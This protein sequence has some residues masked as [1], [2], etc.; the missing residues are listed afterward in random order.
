M[1]IDISV[2]AKLTVRLQLNIQVEMSSRQS[3]CKSC[4]KGCAWVEEIHLGVISKQM[5][6]GKIPQGNNVARG[7]SYI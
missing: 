1:E 3:I 6:L 7:L 4:N 2:L 5:G